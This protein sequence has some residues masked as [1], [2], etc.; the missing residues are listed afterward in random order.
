M[1]L[2]ARAR[3]DNRAGRLILQPS[4]GAARLHERNNWTC[5]GKI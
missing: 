3:L 4:T 5:F 1:A 2:F